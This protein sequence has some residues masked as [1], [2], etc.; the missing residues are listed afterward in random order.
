MSPLDEPHSLWTVVHIFVPF[1]LLYEIGNPRVAIALVFLWELVEW[2]IFTTLGHYGPLFLNHPTYETVWDVWALDIGGGIFGILLAMS[3]Y[4]FKAEKSGNFWN[5]FV[6]KP[7]G[8]W[9]VRTLRFVGIGLIIALLASFGWHCIEFFPSICV[10]GYHLLP[11]GAFGMIPLFAL[12]IWWVGMPVLSYSVLLIFIPV[13]VP[14]TKESQ[15]VSASFVQ[16]VMIASVSTVAFGGC[17]LHRCRNKTSYYS[18][19]K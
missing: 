7:K 6:P 8:R 11:W 15:P 10:D 16:F 5:P 17:L 12:Y 4:Y 18:S 19:L 13:F 3:F 2:L 1:A 9:W 14:V